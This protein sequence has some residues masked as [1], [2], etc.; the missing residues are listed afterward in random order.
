MIVVIEQI[1]QRFDKFQIA[2]Y[3]ALLTKMLHKLH[4]LGE[5]IFD[6]AQCKTTLIWYGLV[7]NQDENVQEKY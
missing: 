2:T 6:L 4:L 1:K 5:D 3:E 7:I